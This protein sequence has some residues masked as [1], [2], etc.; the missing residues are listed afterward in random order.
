MFMYNIW[1]EHSEWDLSFLGE[2]ARE[3]I[4]EFNVPLETPLNG[5][6]AEFLPLADQSPEVANRPP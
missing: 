3:M 6:S 4:A 2:A 1:C 5:P